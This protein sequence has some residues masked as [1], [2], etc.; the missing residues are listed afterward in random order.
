MRKL[1]LNLIFAFMPFTPVQI[2]LSE[3]IKANTKTFGIVLYESCFH[4]FDVPIED[5][6]RAVEDVRKRLEVKLKV[7]KG[8]ASEVLLR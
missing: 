8:K 4:E 6:H 7:G 1:S 5:Y 2:P 3:I